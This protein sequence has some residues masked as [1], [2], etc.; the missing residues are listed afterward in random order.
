MRTSFIKRVS[1][2][3]KNW[4]IPLLIGLL[5][6]FTGIWTF[7]SPVESYLALA[8]IF[9]V[10]FLVSGIME[11]YFAI[12]NRKELDNW[13]WTLA[14]GILTLIIGLM[15]IANPEL[16]I[17]TLP[18]YVGFVLLFRSF[19]AIGMAT[20]L[21]QYGVMDWGTLMVLGVLGVIFSLMLLWNPLFA[22]V[23][24]VVWTG[25]SFII[26]GGFSIYISL[27]LRR[28]HKSWDNVKNDVKAKFNQFQDAVKDRM[29]DIKDAMD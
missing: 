28:L 1:N 16:S 10:S 3:V 18:F 4:W 29:D 6:I 24:I 15:M 7:T 21:K 13:G 2:T 14:F 23:S 11:T 9:S 17:T 22:S 20:D 25:L 19:G 27:K 12:S 8:I 5:F 26:A